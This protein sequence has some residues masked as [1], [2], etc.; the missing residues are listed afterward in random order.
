MRHRKRDCVKK[1]ELLILHESP[2]R[3]V[4]IAQITCACYITPVTISLTNAKRCQVSTH[5]EE[6]WFTL[7]EPALFPLVFHEWRR[8][9]AVFCPVL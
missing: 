8:S 6:S 2:N 3:Q 7:Y 9:V 1:V 4:F 5:P